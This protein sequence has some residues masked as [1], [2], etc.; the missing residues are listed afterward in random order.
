[1]YHAEVLWD[2]RHTSHVLWQLFSW[3]HD[4]YCIT[5][6]RQHSCNY[7]DLRIASSCLCGMF[8]SVNIS[9]TQI[10]YLICF[11][12][13]SFLK[14]SGVHYCCCTGTGF[15]W[16]TLLSDLHLGHSFQTQTLG[17]TL[18]TDRG[19]WD[20][21]PLYL[22]PRCNCE[23]RHPEI[24]SWLLGFCHYLSFKPIWQS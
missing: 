20:G 14:G 16:E 22:H 8:L 10:C 24:F 21:L 23:G 4:T 9:Y 6:D 18:W 11:P 2:T 1:M 17:A 13:L 7:I 15:H 12:T 19:D 3:Q 5:L